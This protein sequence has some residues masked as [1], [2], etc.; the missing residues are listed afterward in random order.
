LHIPVEPVGKSIFDGWLERMQAA[1]KLKSR[2]RVQELTDQ[3]APFVA[4]VNETFDKDRPLFYMK[5]TMLYKAV[6]EGKFKELFEWVKKK[7]A[8][9]P[10]AVVKFFNPFINGTVVKTKPPWLK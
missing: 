1:P 9:H 7:N 3:Y 2:N 6:G 5:A 10:K 8:L 4:W